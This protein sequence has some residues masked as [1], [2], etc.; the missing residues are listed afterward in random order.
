MPSIE[1]VAENPLWEA[2]PDAE[3]LASRAAL[4]AIAAGDVEVMEGAELSILLADDATLQEL[5]RSWRGK[6]KPTNVLSWPAADLDDLVSSPHCGD[7]ALSYETLAREAGEEGKTI[8][9]HFTHLVVHGVLHLLGYDHE[10]DDEAEEMEALEVR[11]LAGLAIA[12]P[13]E[14][15][16]RTTEDMAG[17]ALES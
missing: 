13:Y 16:S 9:D 14:M 10:T 12:D 15:K 17:K 11:V 6:D 8:A 3:D 2:L 7:I 5:N 1:V 4:A